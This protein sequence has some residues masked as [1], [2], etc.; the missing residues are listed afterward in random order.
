MLELQTHRLRLMALT[1][2][3]LKLYLADPQQLERE[4]GFPLSRAILT[5]IVRRAMEIKISTMAAAPE[6]SHPWYTYW[7]IVVRDEPYGAG[8]AGFKGYPN[9]RGEAEI[10]YGIDPAYQRKGYMTEAARALIAWGFEEPNCGSIVAPGTLK[11]NAASNRVLEKAGMTVYEE[12]D[13]T[14]SWRIDRRQQRRIK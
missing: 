14:L 10:G 6:A 8:L 2:K 7:L 3:Q 11:S 4:L 9:S 5:Q 1:L 13:E 12:T